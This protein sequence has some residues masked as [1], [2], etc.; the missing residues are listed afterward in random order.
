MQPVFATLFTELCISHGDFFLPVPQKSSLAVVG[1]SPRPLL[2]TKTL[3]PLHPFLLGNS[4]L[5]NS[6]RVTSSLGSTMTL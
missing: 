4:Y 3:S 6:V 2:Q 5:A 1:T